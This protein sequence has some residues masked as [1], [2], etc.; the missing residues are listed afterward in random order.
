MKTS[1]VFGV[2]NRPM[3]PPTPV[4]RQ[5]VSRVRSRRRT[6]VEEKSGSIFPGGTSSGDG[7][8]LLLR[9]VEAG[10]GVTRSLAACFRERRDPRLG[11]HALPPGR[12]QRIHGL[13]LGDADRNDPDHVRRDPVLAT[14]CDEPDPLGLGRIDPGD[15]GRPLAGAATP[16]PAEAVSTLKWRA[17]AP[18]VNSAGWRTATAWL[19]AGWMKPGRASSRRSACWWPVARA[20]LWV[21]RP[22]PGASV[23]SGMRRG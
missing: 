12:A 17:T 16:K 7:G 22:L 1:S 14:A 2:Q 20:S 6:G 4:L 18:S 10:L 21:A 19:A 8:A 11:A 3:Q 15:C 23:F 9:Q 5:P 13:A